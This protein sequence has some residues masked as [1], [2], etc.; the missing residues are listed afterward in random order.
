MMIEIRLQNSN[1]YYDKSKPIGKAGGFGQVFHGKSKTGEIVAIKQLKIE[2]EAAGH[3][4]LELADDLSKMSFD[5][6]IKIFDYGIDAESG[7]YFIVMEMA[8]YSLQ[9]FI[10]RNKSLSESK[11]V[12]ILN[13]I[14][15]GLKELER[16][17]HRDIKPA[18]ILYCG[19]NY[20]I[21]DF[22][23]ARFV[24]ESTSLNTLK[25]CLSPP[26]AAPEQWRLERATN[27]TDIY[28]VGIIA[29]LLLSGSLPFNS[30]KIEELRE[31]HLS[32][33]PPSLSITNGLLRQLVMMC[34]R[35]SLESRPSVDSVIKQL[36]TIEKKK[37]NS[38]R[39][40]HAGAKVAEKIV[41]EEAARVMTQTIKEK[42][43]QLASDGFEIFHSI[44]SELFQHIKSEAP[45]AK[46]HSH[47]IELGSGKITIDEKF[48]FI[49]EG[50]FPYNKLDIVCGA[51]I[52]VNQ[53]SRFY[54]GR[55]SNLWYMK[56]GDSYRWI[57]VAYWTLGEKVGDEPYA[58]YSESEFRDVDYAA[59]RITHSVQQAFSPKIIDG[60]YMNDFIDRWADRLASASSNNLSHPMSLPEDR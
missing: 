17:V 28:A 23:I 1:W 38:S 47:H 4:E 37:S 14:A 35:K 20:K 9:D 30:N 11:S 60:E 57:E 41:A 52:E 50:S 2:A 13:D 44:M 8:D 31:M 22:G 36:V 51:I 33:Q 7:R 48:R 40:S 42:R 56:R 53:E 29:Y 25:E 54:S 39:L 5:Y 59:G 34:L 58:V 18:N 16:I 26:Y 10:D 32:A 12:D 27:A 49:P 21:A 19:G 6:V 24:E 43:K 3:R 45:V 46:M 15:A 55:S